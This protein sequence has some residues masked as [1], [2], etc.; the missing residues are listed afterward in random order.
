MTTRTPIDSP[1]VKH[2][3]APA[4]FRPRVI[5]LTDKGRAALDEMSA[6]ETHYLRWANNQALPLKTKAETDGD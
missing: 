4:H 1:S 3:K 2:W 6:A 5:V